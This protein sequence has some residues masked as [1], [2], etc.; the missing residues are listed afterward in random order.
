MAAVLEEEDFPWPVVVAAAAA[1]EEDVGA[2]DVCDALAAASSRGFKVGT[3]AT[4]CRNSA[5]Y[6]EHRASRL[7][8]ARP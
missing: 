3:L 7:L 2:A 8:R 5:G 6:R 4:T 1:D